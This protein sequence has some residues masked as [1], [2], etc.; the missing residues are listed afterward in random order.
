MEINTL[1]NQLRNEHEDDRCTART[2]AIALSTISRA[3]KAPNLT[4]MANDHYYTRQANHNLG[5][6]INHIIHTLGLRGFTVGHATND[7]D[8]VTLYFEL[9]KKV[10]DIYLDKD[11]LGS[12]TH[13][14]INGELYCKVPSGN[15]K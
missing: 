8:A 15:G 7:N 11:Q 10:P 9:W 1:N 6:V 14:Q 13:I 2:T 4:V 5:R 12:S 3:I